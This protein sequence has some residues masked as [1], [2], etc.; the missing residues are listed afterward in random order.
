ME[1][2]ILTAKRLGREA[3]DLG[4]ALEDIDLE[5]MGLA[6]EGLALV[7]EGYVEEGMRQ[8]DEATAAA[9]AGE[10]HHLYYVGWVYCYLIYACERVRDYDRAAQWCAKMEAVS[11]DY[12][13]RFGLGIC[14]THYAGVLMWRGTW[15]EAEIELET[16][17]GD[18]AASRPPWAGEGIVRLAELR[19]LQGR[20]EEAEALFDQVEGHPLEWLGR[21]SL[22]YDRG[23]FKTAIE[24]LERLLR[25]LSPEARTERVAA[26]ELVI[27]SHLALDD[28]TAAE[29]SLAELD[30]IATV[31]GSDPI[32][33]SLIFAEGL[34]V[35]ARGEHEIA[36][37]RFETAIDKFERA[38]AAL[39]R[40]RLRL[41]LAR[42]LL[43]LGHSDMAAQEAKTAL[44]ALDQLGAA[45][46][47]ERAK[48]V[49]EEAGSSQTLVSK[50]RGGPLT[51]REIEVLQCIADGLSD[52]QVGSRLFLSEHT[53]HRHVANILGKLAVPSRAAAVRYATQQGLL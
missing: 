17:T 52:K 22:A 10:L 37:D 23:E 28:L 45:V 6:Q 31:I 27:R 12:N 13:C 40:A 21:A 4:R 19:R 8:L 9:A 26:L 25:R 14:R 48:A 53:V 39:D 20:F 15:A 32:R 7:S 18:M 2:D 51:L 34:I 38:G 41:A 11:R 30:S 44:A 5:M 33:A 36:R 24:W 1:D 47:A 16:A 50:E 3:A 42:S 35:A 46:E 49:L 43:A 29:K